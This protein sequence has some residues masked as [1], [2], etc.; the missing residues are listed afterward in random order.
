MKHLLRFIFGDPVT[1]SVTG[2]FRVMNLLYCISKL[3][4]FLTTE[5]FNF[6]RLPHQLPQLYHP[7]ISGLSAIIIQPRHLISFNVTT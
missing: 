7:N 1:R 4:A 3:S 6:T 5:G 2:S